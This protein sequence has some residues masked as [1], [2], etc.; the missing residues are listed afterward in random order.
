MD[1]IKVSSVERSNV[2]SSYRYMIDQVKISPNETTAA[3]RPTRLPP[4]NVRRDHIILTAA[5]RT[6][7]FLALLRA[8]AAS[9]HGHE[10]DH[11][12][13]RICV[14]D[15]CRSGRRMDIPNSVLKSTGGNAECSV[16]GLLC[17]NFNILQKLA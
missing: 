9:D 3:C 13:D 14:A 11:P 16:R 10:T 6:A 1:F 12:Q 17:M 8:A 5:A 2:G 15:P 4:E 7:G